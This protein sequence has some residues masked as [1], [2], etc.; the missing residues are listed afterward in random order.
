MKFSKKWTKLIFLTTAFFCQSQVTIINYVFMKRPT[1][2]RWHG[3]I[4]GEV[5]AQGPCRWGPSCADFSNP[6]I[7][8]RVC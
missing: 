8:R 4:G 1:I 3:A 7:E 2:N 5:F 6:F